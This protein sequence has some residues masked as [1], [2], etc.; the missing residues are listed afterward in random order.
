MILDTQATY[1]L[2]LEAGVVLQQHP[3]PQRALVLDKGNLYE[4]TALHMAVCGGRA[5]AAAALLEVCWVA[6]DTPSRLSFKHACRAARSV[7]AQRASL[8]CSA[9][10]AC[11]GGVG[12][13]QPSC[14]CPVP[15]HLKAPPRLPVCCCCLKLV[16]PVPC[17]LPFP[18]IAGWRFTCAQQQV[19]SPDWPPGPAS[20][21][22]PSACSSAC[23]QPAM[24]P[25]AADGTRAAAWWDSRQHHERPAPAV[26][27]AEAV[28][29][30]AGALHAAA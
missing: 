14:V 1:P 3:E 12:L 27:W 6:I 8:R 23:P 26:G 17:T 15:S 9:P 19:P 22:D 18:A 20:Q 21:D 30:A 16:L 11:T 13:L 29:L 5:E 10:H 28:A 7:S 2:L 24:R 25:G 4:L